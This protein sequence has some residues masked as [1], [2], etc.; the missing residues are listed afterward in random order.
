MRLGASRM[1]AGLSR[2]RAGIPHVAERDIRHR[3]WSKLMLNDGISQTCMAYG[4]TYGSA[5]EPGSEQ[6]RSFVAAMREMLAVGQAEG[7]ALTERNLTQMVQLIEGL[8]GVDM[9]SMAQD[10]IAYRK[11]EVE[12]FSGTICRLARKH[13]IEVPQNEWLYERIRAIESTW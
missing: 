10:R 2:M 11:T 4:G 13:D 9:P 1:C 12:E 6:R 7:V 5:V 3:M 8:D